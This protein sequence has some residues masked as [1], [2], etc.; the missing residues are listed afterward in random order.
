MVAVT[1]LS[2]LLSAG[3]CLVV[4]LMVICLVRYEIEWMDSIGPST[5]QGISEQTM[6]SNNPIARKGQQIIRSRSSPSSLFHWMGFT[7][8]LT[9]SHHTPK[10]CFV[11]L[12]LEIEF[13]AVTTA[14]LFDK[15][16]GRIISYIL[17]AYR[18]R[19]VTV[20]NQGDASH[21]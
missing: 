8:Y 7:W 5:V 16:Q 9:P 4:D 18:K 15:F 20:A 1:E 6:L 11:E 3:G 13:K 10:Q 12:E 2:S 19:L 14:I 17:E 21:S